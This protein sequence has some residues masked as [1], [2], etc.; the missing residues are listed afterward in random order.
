MTP[1]LESS[2]PSHAQVNMVSVSTV[3]TE[4]QLASMDNV[5]ATGVTATLLTPEGV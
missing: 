5:L 4:I 3:A 2:V 1:I